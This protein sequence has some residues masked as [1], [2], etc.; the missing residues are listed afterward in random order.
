MGFS[1]SRIMAV[2]VAIGITAVAFAAMQ[3]RPRQEV[4][5]KILWAYAHMNPWC[6]SPI[7]NS[8]KCGF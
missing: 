7:P 4:R 1:W 2:L 3:P 8:D 5:Y 6:A